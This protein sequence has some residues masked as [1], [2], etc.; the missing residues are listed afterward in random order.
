MLNRSY[1]VHINPVPVAQGKF[2]E[3]EPLYKRA[4]AIHEKVLGSE[5]PGVAS[6]LSNL[7]E[8]LDSQVISTAINAVTARALVISILDSFARALPAKICFPRKALQ[9]FENSQ[10]P[11]QCELLSECVRVVCQRGANL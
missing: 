6:L 11:G 8:L 1:L 5:H 10:I 7:A 9:N 3:A 2:A 4:L